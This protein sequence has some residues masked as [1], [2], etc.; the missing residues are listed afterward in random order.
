MIER[1]RE[2]GGAQGLAAL[3]TFTE[4]D[5]KVW[6]RGHVNGYYRV[7]W[8][9]TLEGIWR[10]IAREYGHGATPSSVGAIAAPH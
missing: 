5:G 1:D 3:P 10:F 2:A 9:E 8:A 6:F 4:K 7:V